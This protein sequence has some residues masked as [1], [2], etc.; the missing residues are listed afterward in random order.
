MPDADHH[1]LGNAPIVEAAIEI[2]VAIS[3]PVPQVAYD[4]IRAAL[5]DRYPTYHALQFIAPHFHIESENEVRT[6]ATTS[7]IGARLESADRKIV[8][9]AKFDGLTV[10]RLQPYESWDS[11]IA[12]VRE[13]WSRY[14]EAF[15]PT[16]VT[17]LGVRYINRIPLTYVDGLIDL[18][19]VFTAG[20]KIPPSL[21]Q[22]LDQYVT[23]LV[24][25]FEREHA[26]LSIVQALEPL[27]VD[28]TPS[29]LLDL[30]AFTNTAMKPDGADMWHRLGTLRRL[31]NDAFFGSL[32]PEIWKGFI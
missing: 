12:E 26:T 30:D 29:A 25:P 3:A 4:N 28:G 1:H 32:Q 14:C 16:E 10:S 24:L 23:R 31:K 27:G 5:A 7:R 13:L 8:L 2:R 11:L 21:P 17:R 15:S 6:E 22:V 18:D 20:P 9:Q 19:K